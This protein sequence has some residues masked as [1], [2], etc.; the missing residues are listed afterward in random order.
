M[1]N[2]PVNSINRPFIAWGSSCLCVL[3][4]VLLSAGHLNAAEPGVSVSSTSK[5][6]ALSS[7]INALT[8]KVRELRK[9]RRKLGKGNK[10]AKEKILQE[11]KQA[12]KLLK[13]K[14]AE[15]QKERRTKARE[16]RWADNIAKGEAKAAQAAQEKKEN[17]KQK[18][19]LERALKEN[20]EAKKQ[21]QKKE[22]ARA[23]SFSMVSL[24]EGDPWRFD[25]KCGRSKYFGFLFLNLEEAGKKAI[26]SAV[27]FNGESSIFAY[28]DSRLSAEKNYNKSTRKLELKTVGY[29][30][31]YRKGRARGDMPATDFFATVDE[32]GTYMQ[33]TVKNSDNCSSFQ[34]RKTSFNKRRNE[35]GLLPVVQ[36]GAP[37]TMELCEDFIDWYTSHGSIK[38]PSSSYYKTSILSAIIDSNASVEKL[39]VAYDGLTIADSK[40]FSTLRKGC[41]R[42][43]KNTVN[44]KSASLMARVNKTDSQTI[45][46]TPRIFQGAIK[47]RKWY[48]WYRNMYYATAIRDVRGV[49]SQ[50]IK[51][52]GE[53]PDSL[54]GLKDI[55]KIIVEGKSKDGLFGVVPDQDRKQYLSKLH[56]I[57]GGIARKVAEEAVAPVKWNDFGPSPEG[58]GKLKARHKDI[59]GSLGSSMPQ[60][61]IEVVD[62]RFN[63]KHK[64]LSGKL[65]ARLIEER[66]T[67]KVSLSGLRSIK[68][69]KTSYINKYG[70]YLTQRDMRG[71]TNHFNKQFD[72]LSTKSSAHISGWLD[73][74]I[75]SSKSGIDE[76]DNISK[77]I[78]GT[79]INGL[80]KARVWNKQIAIAQVLQKKRRTIRESE[81]I[82]EKGFEDMRAI[83]CAK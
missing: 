17:L 11:I 32:S 4:I 1:F 39:G 55:N 52:S 44:T 19:A 20:T 62:K 53:L 67:I 70:S 68:R 28:G 26:I 50:K 33:G 83:L 38:I 59:R 47:G 10:G 36:S 60:S 66:G 71:M 29:V 7:E 34:A 31:T 30:N 64:E 21:V 65:L 42:L 2:R 5:E 78:F 6:E 72:D 49:L 73:K 58:I 41:R 22:I 27:P 81:C 15:R 74:E 69:E 3:L 18:E 45:D 54:E 57:Q 23:D 12:Q 8:I 40:A 16:Q 48:Q 24:N 61:G 51:L 37:I 63:D 14:K 75:P 82:F 80:E 46:L 77:D 43:L 9:E 13:S 56:E 35:K 25:M 79:S 76:L